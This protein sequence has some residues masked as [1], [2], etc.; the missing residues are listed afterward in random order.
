M[1][2]DAILSRIL[3]HAWQSE[4]LSDQKKLRKGQI[5]R[6]DTK[7]EEEIQVVRQDSAR[8]QHKRQAEVV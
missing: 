8:C 7:V 1:G 6:W 4:S 3:T 2:K 5:E